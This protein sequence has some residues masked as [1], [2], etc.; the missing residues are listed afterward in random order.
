MKIKRKIFLGIL[1]WIA[2]VGIIHYTR[3]SFN[4]ESPSWN[5]GIHHDSIYTSARNYVLSFAL[6]LSSPGEIVSSNVELIRGMPFNEDS[7]LLGEICND[8]FY[9]ILIVLIVLKFPQKPKEQ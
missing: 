1:I 6:I 7:N 9:A 8:V 4:K 3:I 5:E 2:L